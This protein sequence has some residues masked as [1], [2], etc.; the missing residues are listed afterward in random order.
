MKMAGCYNYILFLLV[1]EINIQDVGLVLF[2]AGV[3]AEPPVLQ[4]VKQIF[5][6]LFLI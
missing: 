3:Q 1:H 4:A 2:L 6:Y 5:T